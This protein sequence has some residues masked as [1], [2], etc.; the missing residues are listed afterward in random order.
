MFSQEQELRGTAKTYFHFTS[1]VGLPLNVNMSSG[2]DKTATTAG[3]TLV[4]LTAVRLPVFL[5]HLLRGLVREENA[6]R[7]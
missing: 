7:F 1:G 2:S 3:S 6:I 4:S 5:L